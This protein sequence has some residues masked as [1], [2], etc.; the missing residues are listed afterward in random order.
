MYKAQPCTDM[1]DSVINNLKFVVAC[2]LCLVF[3]MEMIFIIDDC[4]IRVLTAL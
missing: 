3:K 2:N 4:S 1:N